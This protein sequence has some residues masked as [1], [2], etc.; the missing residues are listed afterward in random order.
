M[1]LTTP[2]LLVASLACAV[3]GVV[4]GVSARRL[5][6]VWRRIDDGSDG[7]AAF[8]AAAAVRREVH[9]TSL[10]VVGAVIAAAG[11]A[12]GAAVAAVASLSLAA[13]V[14]V[15][16]LHGRR[17]AEEAR[18]V[19]GRSRVERRALEVLAQEESAPRRWAARL[20]PEQLPD[21]EGFAVGAVYRAG[22]GMMAGDFYDLFRTAPHRLVA[23]IGDVTGHGIEPSITAFQTKYL[24]RVFSEQYRDPGQALTEL[25]RRLSALGRPEELVSLCVAVFDTNAGTLRYASAGHPPS[26]LWHDREARPLPAT[27]PLLS[28]D[29]EADFSSRELPLDVGDLLVLYTDGLTEARDG[30]QMFGEDRVGAT[31]RKGPNTAPQKLVEQLLASAEAFASEPIADDVAIMA[32]RRV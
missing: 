25:N 5:H 32:V 13:P 27:G 11:A 7:D 10:Y 6:R 24:L 2:L 21:L 30:A 28:L 14:A 31:V 29:P 16:V 15:S 8:L 9:A 26:W 17:S 12:G 3:G 23:V 20:A 19:E 4:W 1:S 22:T 18:R